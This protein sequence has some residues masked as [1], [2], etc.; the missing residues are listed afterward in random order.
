MYKL[1]Y[2]EKLS[3]SKARELIFAMA[4]HGNYINQFQ[5]NFKTNDEVKAFFNRNGIDFDEAVEKCRSPKNKVPLRFENLNPSTWNTEGAKVYD[6]NFE[7]GEETPVIEG[8]GTFTEAAYWTNFEESAKAFDRAVKETSFPEFKTAVTLAIASIEAYINYR[9][10]IWNKQN[11]NGIV[12][13]EISIEEKINRWIPKMTNGK[14]LDKS[15]E[16]WSTYKKLK[17]IRDDE[18]IHIKKRYSN[19]TFKEL[20]KLMN[21]YKGLAHLLMSLHILF[22]D[23]VPS[24]II[25]HTF[26][27]ELEL[28][29]TKD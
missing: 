26:L 19:I 12:D 4:K 13:Y 5:F 23:Y 29:K 11:Q 27:P 28:V 14:R 20:V 17:R 15:T 6:V 18:T 2:K 8:D 16:P 25:R 1:Q 10:E 21:K 7:T 3:K 9:A 24:I 22:S